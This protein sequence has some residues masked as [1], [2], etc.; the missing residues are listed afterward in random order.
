MDLEKN[1]QRLEILASKIEELGEG[2]FVTTDELESYKADADKN[3]IK[4][5]M[6]I[7]GG[8][9]TF[10]GT[11]P[12][13]GA[14]E[15]I[16]GN[17]KTSSSTGLIAIGGFIGNAHA[18]NGAYSVLIGN[19]LN[20]TSG[21]RK[22]LIGQ[23]ITAIGD[24]NIR[25]G[26]SMDIESI[27][28]V[29]NILIGTGIN[30]KNSTLIAKNF[31]D[32]TI[33]GSYPNLSSIDSQT[34]PNGGFIVGNGPNSSTKQNLFSYVNG[35]FYKGNSTTGYD[36]CYFAPADE[37]LA[38]GGTISSTALVNANKHV[39]L[40]FNSHMCYYSYED[41]T[42]VYYT[43]TRLNGTSLHINIIGI[44]KETGVATFNEFDL[45]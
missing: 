13:S 31:H 5:E 45:N 35:L 1:K 42:S 20:S 34:A 27:D 40:S 8:N 37:T 7:I 12:A 44:N 18:I 26:N 24:Y 11:A 9:I 29:R 2:S 38:D 43:S 19:Q 41:S 4:N 10:S 6:P 14:S 16:L 17:V 32:F 39:P 21:T 23:G 25:I 36:L 33:L 22:I 28:G 15:V 30:A 3:Y